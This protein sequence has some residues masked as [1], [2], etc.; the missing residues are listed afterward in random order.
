M[1]I[2]IIRHG[3]TA[4]NVNNK[5]HLTGDVEQL[6]ENGTEQIR[7]TSGA[8]KGLGI[9]NI[10]CSK[11]ARAVQSAEIIAKSLECEVSEVDGLEERN[12]GDYSNMKWMEI[13]EI[14]DPLTLEERFNFLPPKG[15]TWKDLE[16]RL[17]K[18]IMDSVEQNKDNNIAFV[19][20]AGSIRA[21]IPALLNISRDQSFK[22]TP[23]NASITE[24]EY[25]EGE[26]KE[27]RIDDFSH[28]TV[29]TLV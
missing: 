8:L 25:I 21:I 10:F 14:L 1:K 17:V 6:N 28:L 7:Q 26:F 27:V 12:W 22:Y 29:P 13:K 23:S 11:E 24:L 3:E 2:F 18:T 16:T 20:H 5:M 9:S 15:E 19:T 4:K